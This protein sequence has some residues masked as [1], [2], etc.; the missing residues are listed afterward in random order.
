MKHDEVNHPAHYTAY[1]G[2]EVIQLTEQV[3]FNRGNAVA[4]MDDEDE[5]F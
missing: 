4:E 1:E 2:F 3:N 5:E